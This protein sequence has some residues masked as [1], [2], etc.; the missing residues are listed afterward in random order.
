MTPRDKKAIL[1]FLAIVGS[2]IVAAL[3]FVQSAFYA[4]MNAN[5][6]WSAEEAALWAYGALA[7]SVGFT[8]LCIYFIIKLL[9]LPR[10]RNAT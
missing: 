3:A 4:W 6:S 10:T 1:L 2:G 5:G 8:A 7:V 9:R